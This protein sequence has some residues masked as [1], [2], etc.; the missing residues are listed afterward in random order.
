M[1]SMY[2]Q[3]KTD[4]SKLT[5]KMS[6][7]NSQISS[8][9]IYQ[10]PSDAPV[11]LA[12]SMGIREN[13]TESKQ[14]LRN[15]SYGK[16]WLIASETS[17]SQMQERLT[18]VKNL[19]LQG[20]NDSQDANSRQAIAAEVKTILAEMVSLGN[21]KFGNRYVFAGTKT[22]GYN[23]GETPF[24]LG[25]DG[26]VTYTGN[27]EDISVQVSQGVKNSINKNGYEAIEKSG[28]FN[29]VNLLYNALIS[30]SRADIEVSLSEIEKTFEY[31]GVQ[32]SD[33]GSISNSFDV[34]EEIADN[35]VFASKGRLSDIEDA[36]Y[37][38][39]ITE[40]KTAET[41]YQASLASSAKIMALSL[42]D[43]V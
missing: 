11:E 15:I 21:S 20:A 24:M 37:V 1:N 12:F 39:A 5:E 18:R 26:T 14:H 19:G 7:T 33:I 28:V 29:S 34:K 35:L 8:G 25:S 6:Q 16:G 38:E 30:D 4:L 40:F 23:Q 36:D 22:T 3:I 42:V 13:I 27:L 10:K 2:D 31:L 9:K 32:I 17:L 41:A 43:Y